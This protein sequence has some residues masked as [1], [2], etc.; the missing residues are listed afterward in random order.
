M[1][2]DRAAP[3]TVLVCDSKSGSLRLVAPSQL[4]LSISTR[5]TTDLVNTFDVG[6]ALGAPFTLFLV[7]NEC[8]MQV[9]VG[10]IHGI[11]P[12]D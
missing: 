11:D 10:M 12:T 7:M 2:I 5:G 3:L 4:A 1:F 9:T 8:C 6:F